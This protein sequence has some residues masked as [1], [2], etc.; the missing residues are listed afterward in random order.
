MVGEREYPCLYVNHILRFGNN[1]TVIMEVKEFISRCFEMKDLGVGAIIL[2]NKLLKDDN[3]GITLLQSCYM[4][5]ILSR[6]SVI[7]TAS[8]LRCIIILVFQFKRINVNILK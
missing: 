8:L 4:E 5:K 1:L 7:A 2:N 3:G 6:V